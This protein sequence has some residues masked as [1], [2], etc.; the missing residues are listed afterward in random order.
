MYWSGFLLNLKN[1]H[2]AVESISWRIWNNT[3]WSNREVYVVLSRN[4]TNNCKSLKANLLGFKVHLLLS[5]ARRNRHNVE[6]ENLEENDD[7][8]SVHKKVKNI[9]GTAKKSSHNVFEYNDENPI[10]DNQEKVKNGNN[11]NENSFRKKHHKD[12]SKF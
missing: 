10:I 7:T 9:T 4:Y 11:V 5:C 3:P 8:F 2:W 12:K 1:I 6:T